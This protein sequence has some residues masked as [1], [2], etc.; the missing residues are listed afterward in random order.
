MSN[1]IVF[2]SVK[3]AVLWA[4]E[5]LQRSHVKNTIGQLLSKPGTGELTRQDRVDIAHTISNLT[6]NCKP[7]RGAC[8]KAVYGGRDKDLERQLGIAIA[9]ELKSMGVAKGKRTEKLI[10][11]GE[12]TIRS[13]RYK[14]LLGK[15]YGIKRMAKDVGISRERFYKA[16]SWRELRR[17]SKLRVYDWLDM[18]ETELW[19]ELDVRGWIV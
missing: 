14:E 16:E 19:L 3:A 5:T 12:A 9:K 7:Y 11:L 2:A 4:E 18:V 6:A 1:E 13:I 10:A 8:M 15:R 17:V